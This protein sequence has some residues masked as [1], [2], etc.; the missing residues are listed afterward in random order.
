MLKTGDSFTYHGK[1]ITLKENKSPK[2]S[3]NL[4][5]TVDVYAP[6]E[7]YVEQWIHISKKAKWGWDQFISA[8][9]KP[10]TKKRS[11]L[12]SLATQWKNA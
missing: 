9:P 5:A 6:I 12:P 3:N 2:H 11:D 1:T 8:K 10:G 7:A 4:Q